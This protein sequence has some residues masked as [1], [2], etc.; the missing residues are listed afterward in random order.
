MSAPL[1][2]RQFLSDVGGGVL[3]ARPRP[4]LNEPIMDAPDRG[5]AR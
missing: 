3:V 1:T 4:H 5:G 2:R